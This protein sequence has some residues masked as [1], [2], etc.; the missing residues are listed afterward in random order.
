MTELLTP[1]ERFNLLV[2]D[3]KPDRCLA[4]PL[5]TS[6]SAAVAGISLREYYTDGIALARSQI[7]AVEEYGH[8]AISVFSEVGIVAE[9]MGSE[10]EYPEDDLPVLKTP[11]LDRIEIGRLSVPDP[12]RD[13]RLHVYLDAIRYAYDAIADRCP[14]L[15]YVPAPFT[16]AMMLS[17][18]DR[19]LGDT[20]RNPERVKAI[21][22][23]SLKSTIRFL[24]DI[25]NAGGLPLIVDPLASSSVISPRLYRDLAMPYEQA[26]IRYLHRF[27]FDVIL[28]ICGDTNPILDL[29]P[30]TGADL[31]SLDEVELIDA[32]DKLSKK[33]RIIGNYDTSAIM[34][35]DPD[36]IGHKVKEM[37]KLGMTSEKGYVASTGCEV[38]IRTPRENVKAF[39]SAAKEVG[40]YWE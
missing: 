25:I 23:I 17:N 12:R 11:A 7:A 5:I 35:L 8:D 3:E 15:A 6:H 40:W 34:N 9:A 31:I 20:I 19:F 33:M 30:E 29:L 16:T 28:H 22:E 24:R 10:F 1:R 21:M 37:V 2:I 39:I 13:G 14:I 27:D 32:M 36:E 38:P 4:L 18:S 26:L